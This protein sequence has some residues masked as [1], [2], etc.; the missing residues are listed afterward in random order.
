MTGCLQT[1]RV[2]HQGD[3]HPCGGRAKNEALAPRL[4]SGTML[5]GPSLH[6]PPSTPPPSLSTPVLPNAEGGRERRVLATVRGPEMPLCILPMLPASCIP[7][8]TE[9]GGVGCPFNSGVD[10]HQTGSRE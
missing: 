4:G 6:G 1:R 9:P 5:R 7:F 10:C 8:S 2:D 3:G